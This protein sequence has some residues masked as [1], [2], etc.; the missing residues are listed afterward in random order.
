MGEGSMQEDKQ[1]KMGSSHKAFLG[2]WPSVESYA[3]RWLDRGDT[4]CGTC[5]GIFILAT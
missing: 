2:L 5:D 4:K 3:M 1:D